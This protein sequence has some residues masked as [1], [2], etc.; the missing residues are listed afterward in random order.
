[1]ANNNIY[2]PPGEPTP[3][4]KIIGVRHRRVQTE[5]QRFPEEYFSGSDVNVY[6]GDTWVEDL[7][8]LSFTLQEQVNPVFGY[9]SYTW[10]AVSRGSRLVQGSFRLAFRESSYLHR[11]LEHVGSLGDGASPRIAYQM[12]DTGTKPK[13]LAKTK[14]T[15]EELIERSNGEDISPSVSSSAWPV[16]RIGDSGESVGAL[17]DVILSG[18]HASLKSVSGWTKATTYKA[19]KY[20]DKGN[21]VKELQRR[22]NEYVGKAGTKDVADLKVDG[23]YGPLVRTA[24]RKFQ[25]F[26]N[27]TVDGAAGLKTLQHLS[28]SIARTSYFGVATKIAVVRYQQA[29]KGLDADGIVGPATQASLSKAV[30]IAGASYGTVAQRDYGNFE[31]EI[32]GRSF[33]PVDVKSSITHFYNTSNQDGLR[34]RGFDIYINFGPLPEAIAQN[35]GKLPAQVSFNTTVKAIRNVQITGVR[36]ILDASGQALEEEYTFLA[37]DID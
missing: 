2:I 6:M 19:M 4:E 36:Q 20:G 11:I 10:D 37:R 21:Q 25:T 13:W 7:T 1:M 35:S 17:Q 30:S 29:T 22:L 12:G 31:A 32:W 8:G 18:R 9:Q 15:I 14:E 28:Y 23:S 34:D 27:I 3:D 16:M 24:V 26:A 33:Q 5:Y